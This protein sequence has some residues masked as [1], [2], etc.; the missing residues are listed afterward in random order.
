MSVARLTGRIGDRNANMP[1][2]KRV[3]ILV[4]LAGSILLACVVVNAVAVVNL[5]DSV[6]QVVDR[7]DP[8]RIYAEEYLNAL[9]DEETGSRGYI[10]SGDKSFLAP[11]D[12]GITEQA[13]AMA[14]LDHEVAGDSRLVADSR[15]AEQAAT[16][17]R[18]FASKAITEASAG[19]ASAGSVSTSL[20][21]KTLFGH[22]RAAMTTLNSDLSSAHRAADSRL[23]DADHEL[24]A[25]LG[26]CLLALLGVFE[27]TWLLIRRWVT[28]P[29][30]DLATDVRQVSGGDF[31]HEVSA[32][33]SPEVR[34][35]ALDV[36]AMR[37][38]IVSDLGEVEKARSTLARHADLLEHSNR[39]LEQFAYIASHDLQEPLRKISSFSE[40]VQ[41][42]YSDQLDD[43]GR[44][45]LAFIADGA[46]RM[47]R[48]INDVLELSRVGLS[49]EPAEEVD[50][51][52]AFTEARSN[53]SATIESTGALV[54]AK[55]LPV[56]R[57]DSSLLTALFQ[58]LI[59]N[60]LKFRSSES[61]HVVVS[62]TAEG[63]DNWRISVDDNGIGIDPQH[64][65]R[66][67]AMFQRLHRRS[68]YPGT[69]IGLSL[70][71]RI[72]EHHGGRI[73]LDTTHQPGTSIVFTLPR[74]RA[75]EDR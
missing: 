46:H 37:A 38:R 2:S 71:Q 75:A 70:C 49:G 54:A 13:T 44:E 6:R 56:V 4:A 63:E 36:D 12:Q 28:A 59:A 3:A 9:V 52:K 39:E 34:S 22:F 14:G 10:L 74:N 7:I 17:W 35:L 30:L 66:I 40:L 23:D 73:W 68:D 47:Q 25:L 69:G 21:G 60:S 19:D 48:L 64:S 29:I 18:A 24:I 15:R 31:G 58:N 57:G 62:A 45:F 42:R 5:N 1:L 67:F 16:A 26:L 51:A 27:A 65:E 55:S 61:P 33:G 53:L 32:A 43:R 50:L 20:R 11:Y 72:V 8:A 41:R